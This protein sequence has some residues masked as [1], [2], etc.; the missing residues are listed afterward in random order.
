MVPSAWVAATASRATRASAIDSQLGGAS[1][2]GGVDA[3]WV[4]PPSRE[5]TMKTPAI[6]NSTTAAA[7]AAAIRSFLR[8]F[9]SVLTVVVRGSLGG[10]G[11]LRL[12]WLTDA[13]WANM[14]GSGGGSEPVR[15]PD[16]IDFS[17][18]RPLTP[19]GSSGRDCV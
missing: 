9:L 10:A 7:A 16:G 13:V 6:S 17:S 4:E 1:V 15:A 12:D 3:V 8:L 11:H 19:E 14:F 18:G 2:V 5:V